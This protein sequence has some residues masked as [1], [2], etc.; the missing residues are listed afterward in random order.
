MSDYKYTTL[1]R[2]PYLIIVLVI[3][4]SLMGCKK[5]N[6]YSDI[7]KVTYSKILT[8]KGNSENKY[9][10]VIYSTTCKYCQDLESFVVK[11]YNKVNSLGNKCHNNYPKL[12]VLCVDNT[13]DNKDIKV[14]SDDL[15]LNFIGTSNYQDIKFSAEPGLVEVTNGQVTNFISSKNTNRPYTDIKNYLNNILS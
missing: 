7:R 5:V 10:V 11:Y 15:Y 4:F 3:L 12:Y 13:E 9:F 6:K 8:Q 1:K 14:T 2:I